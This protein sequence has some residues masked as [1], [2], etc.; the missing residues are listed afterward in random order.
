MKK[1]IRSVVLKVFLIVIGISFLFPM[2]WMFVMSFKDKIDIVRNPFGLPTQWFASNYSAAL[3]K[4]NF[5]SALKNSLLYTLGTCVLALLFGT[6]AAYAIS[7]MGWKHEN[8]VRTY[9]MMGLVIP[10]QLVMIPLYSIIVDLGIRKSALSIILPYTA[11]QLPSTI[12]MLY[13]FLRGLPRE[14]EEAARIDGCNVYQCFWRVIV[15]TL[16]PALSTRFVLVF[17][18]I[19][20]EY[21]LALI[22]ASGKGRTPLTIELNKFFV[23]QVGTPHWGYI[24][25]AMI[26][27]SLPAMVVYTIGNKQIENALTAGSILK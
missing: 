18:N 12:L 23:S 20:N 10:M 24:G 15:P 14:L 11:F 6:L 7:R 17:L 3:A 2:Y 5:L 13:A 19:W 26:L 25:A 27:A 9:F 22:L 1:K 8:K 4:M 16:K 21:N